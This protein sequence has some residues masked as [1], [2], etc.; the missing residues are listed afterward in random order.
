M[1]N[2]A[3]IWGKTAPDEGANFTL[4]LLLGL[5]APSAYIFLK[6]FFDTKVRSREQLERI[7]KIPFLAAIPHHGGKEQLVFKENSKSMIS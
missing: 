5:F 4:A 7:T 2:E 6:I 1:V 3:E